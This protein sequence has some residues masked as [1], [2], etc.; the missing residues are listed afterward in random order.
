MIAKRRILPIVATTLLVA[1]GETMLEPPSGSKTLSLDKAPVVVGPTDDLQAV[2]DALPVGGTI[3]LEEGVYD[4]TAGGVTIDKPLTIDGGGDAVLRDQGNEAI[5]VIVT[6]LQTGTVTFRG[7]RFEGGSRGI[8]AGDNG[9]QSELV[10]D[11]CVFVYGGYAV[12]AQGRGLLLVRN[13]LFREVG[14]IGVFGAGESVQVVAVDNTFEDMPRWGMQV[15]SGAYGRFEGNTLNNCAVSGGRCVAFMT[16]SSGE[17]VDNE[18]NKTRRG[19]ETYQGN[20]LIR[21]N[22]ITQFAVAGVYVWTAGTVTGFDNVIEDVLGG[23]T[24][25]GVDGSTGNVQV[26]DNKLVGGDGVGIYV[27]ANEFNIEGT[28]CVGP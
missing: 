2:I 10:V 11:D 7:L 16:G 5:I 4:L 26:I 9:P 24:D 17:A 6:R 13:S 18:V 27:R 20:V 25:C 19:I 15:Q 3:V 23:D 28:T 21:D 14:V 8:L 22:K 12:Q 1:C